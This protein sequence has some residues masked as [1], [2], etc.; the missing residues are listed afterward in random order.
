[1]NAKRKIVT[2]NV[3]KKSSRRRLKPMFL[4]GKPEKKAGA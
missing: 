3:P 2:P 1:M 4:S